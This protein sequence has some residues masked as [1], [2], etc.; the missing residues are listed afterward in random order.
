MRRRNLRIEQWQEVDA[1][2]TAARR[3]DGSNRW[4]RPRFLERRRAGFGGAG[5]VQASVE[6]AFLEYGVETERAELRE[7]GFEFSRAKGLAGATMA[8]RSPLLSTRGL[9]M[10]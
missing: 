10:R 2:V 4:V 3:D 1:S 9:R 8:T 6:N 7:A 5:R